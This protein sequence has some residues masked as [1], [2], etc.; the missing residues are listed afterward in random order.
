MHNTRYPITLPQPFRDVLADSFYDTGGVVAD[1]QRL[2]SRFEIFI[3]ILII[4][5][6]ERHGDCFNQDVVV[7]EGGYGKFR[8]DSLIFTC[9]YQ[10][11]VVACGSHV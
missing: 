4:C 1:Q 8:Y 9:L 11:T 5:W 3:Q 7:S 6:V 10:A 2:C